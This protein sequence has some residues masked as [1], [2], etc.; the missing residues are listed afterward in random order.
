MNV[1]FKI[2][3]IIA[4]SGDDKVKKQLDGTTAHAEKSSHKIGSSLGKV[5]GVIGKAT[6]AAVSATA[7]GVA[8]ITK[9]AISNYAEYEQLVGGAQ[10]L[11]GEAFDFIAEKAANAY[12]TVQ[13]SQNDYLQQVNGF[14]T[15]LKT[16]L[17]GNEQ[18][19]A[20]L[21]HRIIVAEA[22]IVAATGATQESVQNAFNGIMKNN[23]T[24]V[25]NLGLGIK[26]SREGYQAMIDSVNAYNAEHG[27]AT[28]YQIDNL[29]DCQSALIDYVEMQG[30]AGYA[31]NEA[32]TTI[33]GSVSS[34]KAAWENMLVGFADDNA[35]FKQLSEN[36]VN[37]ATT[38]FQNI[39]PRIVTAISGIATFAS[40]IMPQVV[41]LITAN[42]PMLLTAGLQIVSSLGNAIITNLPA[43]I[44]AVIG[45]LTQ[46]T[47][48]LTQNVNLLVDGA[49]QIILAISNGL[50][51]NLPTL[52]AAMG[53]LVFQLGVAI[54]ENIPNIVVAAAQLIAAFLLSLQA[55][56]SSFS[57]AAQEWFNGICETIS[58]TYDILYNA[59]DAAL[60][61]LW[62]GIMDV[63]N[64]IASW[65]SE[66]WNSIFS[67]LSANV[68]V[69]VSGGG[70]PGKASGLDYVPYNNYPA[71]LHEGE[72]VLT[73]SEARSWRNGDSGGSTV[74]RTAESVTIPISL[75]L[76]GA[77]IAKKLYKYNLAESDFHGT[78]LI[79]A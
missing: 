37:S 43:I 9:M 47:N 63:L 66:K 60:A 12:S 72:A 52:M 51:T 14:A 68:D 73:R 76:D 55:A 3:G 8:A 19:A 54:I 39:Q 77:V 69:G 7:T 35:D 21:A 34:M 30:L 62:A 15:G 17:G 36:L 79:K 11:Y 5:A 2:L 50:M 25:D 42:L 33:T 38:V 23:F 16:A 13:M 6:I 78:S 58:N 48:Y 22:D 31:A 71:M 18:A 59:A 74:N 26:A 67:G 10:L 29:A 4:L 41:N 53:Q 24:M 75:E 46:I 28:Q 61:G 56:G 44:T 20:E 32:S 64:S 65:V 40:Q 57:E 70:A 1:I 49:I 27:K 45:I